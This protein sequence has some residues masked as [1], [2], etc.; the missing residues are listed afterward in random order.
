MTAETED[1]AFAA[2]RAH[3][4]GVLQSELW[5]E[6]GVDSRKCSRLVKKLLDEGRIER[7]EYRK[8]GI[9][10]YV[11]R[12]AKTPPEPNLLLAGNELIPC[13]ACELECK[14][15]ECPLLMD[16][17]YQLAIEEFTE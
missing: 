5:K 10:T 11:L 13:V 17:M 8:E 3:P 7:I 2:I 9:K 16:W 12:A 6:L 15:E 14:V 1:D 4:G